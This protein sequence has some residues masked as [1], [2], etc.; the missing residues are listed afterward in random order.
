MRSHDEPVALPPSW[1]AASPLAD[2]ARAYL[3]AVREGRRGPA[4]QLI[5]DLVAGGTRVRDV[6]MHIFQ[7]ALYEIGRLWELNQITVAQEHYCT[8]ITQFI[9]AQLYPSIFTGDRSG[10]SIITTSV[11]GDLHE[12]GARMVS[13]FLEMDGWDTLY[14]GANTPNDAVVATLRERRPQVLAVSA[15][16]RGHVPQVASLVSE[17]RRDSSLASTKIMVGGQPF[18]AAPELYQKIGADGF[19]RDAEEALVV[20]RRLVEE[21]SS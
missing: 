3:A 16:M 1:V 15:T 4:T 14:L 17:V 11:G 5:L 13:D 7:P 18:N 20:A 8:A 19:A 12:I 9:M 10:R 6:Y 2:Q 21:R